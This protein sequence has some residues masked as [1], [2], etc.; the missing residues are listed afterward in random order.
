MKTV[1][2]YRADDDLL[3]LTLPDPTGLISR[4][5]GNFAYDVSG[6]HFDIVDASDLRILR[7]DLSKHGLHKVSKKALNNLILAVDIMIGLSTAMNN[8][9]IYIK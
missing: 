4:I 7:D 2:I 3:L 6:W 1:N 5:V 9:C 8:K